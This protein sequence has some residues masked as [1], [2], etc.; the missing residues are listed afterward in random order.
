M[1]KN[2]CSVLFHS[3]PTRRVIEN[4]K[5]IAKKFKK[6]KYTII[7]SF[8]AKIGWGRMRKR[9]KKNYRSV[10]FH[11]YLSAIENSKKLAKNSKNSKIPLWIRFNPKLNGK[12][13][14][15]EKIKIIVLFCSYAMRNRKFPKN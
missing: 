13:C 2:Y 11:S 8:Q 14:E 3:I 15:R 9:E 1:N 12:G 7:D 4:S 6:L 10:S 5:K